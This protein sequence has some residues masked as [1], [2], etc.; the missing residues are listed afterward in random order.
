M[1]LLLL[2]SLL[3]FTACAKDRKKDHII[4]KIPE[5]SGICYYGDTG[6]LFAVSD[7]GRVY[8]LSADGKILHKRDI[9]KYDLEGIACDPK[10]NRLLA[11]DEGKDNIVIID[12]KTL[13]I[14]KKISVK[15]SFQGKKILI[16]DEEYG[17]EG[18]TLDS[19]GNI[20]LA[21]Q[22]HRFYP[23]KDPSIIVTVKNLTHKKTPILSLINPRIKDI[24]GLAYTEN[25]LYF[26]S[27]T[28]D[29]LYRYNL[30]TRKRDFSAKLPKFAQEGI[31]FDKNGFIYFADDNG[32]IFKYRTK[33]F[34]IK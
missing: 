11:V 4:A 21:N 18:I 28:N 6:T 17:L 24:S 2:L 19:S 1:K 15:R 8:E 27:D 31:T 9:G 10:N 20:Y 16:R 22:S 26:V 13:H 23:H 14:Q 12:A 3:F 25:G 34:E 7:R 33:R 32:H 29:K 5:A 30:I